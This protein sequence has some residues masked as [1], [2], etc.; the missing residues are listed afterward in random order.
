LIDIP[1]DTDQVRSL[2]YLQPR[3][4][5]RLRLKFFSAKRHKKHKRTVVNIFFG[6]GCASFSIPC[7]TIC[8]PSTDFGRRNGKPQVRSADR[9]HNL[10]GKTVTLESLRGK[11]VLLN[12]WSTLC[13]PCTA[14]M[15]SL[16]RLYI[17]L[18]AGGFG[19]F[20]WRSIQWTSLSGNLWR[21]MVSPSLVLLDKRQGGLFPRLW[22]SRHSR[23]V[24]HRSK[25]GHC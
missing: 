11:A 19:S 21:K 20:L 25:R 8:R 12:F 1:L 15:P 4:I 17:A 16:N 3:F 23:N 22:R 24:F 10:S 7:P 13:S 6:G 9:A 2:V 18:K 5:I 14:E